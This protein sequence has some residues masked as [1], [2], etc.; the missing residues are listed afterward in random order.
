MILLTPAPCID[1]QHSD[2]DPSYTS[3]MCMK[4]LPMG[5]MGC[6]A[7]E[8]EVEVLEEAPEMN[9]SCDHPCKNGCNISTVGECIRDYL[10][11]EDES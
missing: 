9:I 2:L 1:C 11:E 5:D 6:P 8:E 4:N 7:Y 10:D 3:L